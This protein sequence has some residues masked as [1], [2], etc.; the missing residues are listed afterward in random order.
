M[1]RSHSDHVS[2]S[3]SSLHWIPPRKS[4]LILLQTG[5][6]IY[7]C[8]KYLSLSRS[9]IHG[10]LRTQ[11]QHKITA[12]MWWWWTV[13]WVIF[14]LTCWETRWKKITHIAKL[15]CVPSSMLYEMTL[16]SRP[17]SG[18]RVLKRD[19]FLC[20]TSAQNTIIFCLNPPVSP[21]SINRPRLT[22]GR[23]TAWNFQPKEECDILRRK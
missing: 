10:G 20:R 11:S 17:Y 9:A 19:Q 14:R 16:C 3:L 15:W 4:A 7:W 1:G 8:K 22:Y 13:F 5:S 6:A 2:P 21:L 23:K 18:P 12:S